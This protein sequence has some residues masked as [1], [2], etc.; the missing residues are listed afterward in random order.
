MNQPQTIVVYTQSAWS[1]FWSWLGVL[2]V[3][4]GGIALYFQ[5]SGEKD[6]LSHL[7]EKFVQ[8]DKHGTDKIA[9]ISIEGVIVHGEGFVKQQIDKVRHDDH[10]K[11]VVLRVDSPG[12]TVTGSDYI[13]H[14]LKRLRD[15]RKLPIVVSMGGMAAS[16]GYYVS[17]AVGQTPDTIFAEPTCET[18]SIG[19]MIPHYD[20]HELLDW[21]HI[22]D[23]SLAT[24]ERKLMLSPTREMP[25]EHRKLIMEHL[26]QMFA[27]F[28][29]IIQEGRPAFAQDSSALDK[30]ATGEIFTSQQALDNKLIDKVGFIE[31]AIARAAELANIDAEKTRV[32]KYKRPTSVL[33][34]LGYVESESRSPGSPAGLAQL[35]DLTAPRAWYL[36]TSLPGVLTARKAD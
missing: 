16:G 22:K 14:H 21:A 31:D 19:V 25:E 26:N 23:D 10:V 35:L 3:I 24:H 33:S 6:E 2:A 8:G 11:A 15:E 7:S 17:M 36:A 20:I 32:I 27:R 18:G 4:V 1:R 28:K 13:Y 9:V 12:G 34:E 30:L 29:S 5:S